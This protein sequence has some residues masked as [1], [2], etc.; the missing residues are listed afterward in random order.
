M[1][2]SSIDNEEPNISHEDMINSF[3]NF[4]WIKKRYKEFAGIKRNTKEIYYY[5]FRV[6]YELND[7]SPIIMFCKYI[8]EVTTFPAHNFEVKIVMDTKLKKTREVNCIRQFLMYTVDK[9]WTYFFVPYNLMPNNKITRVVSTSSFCQN[10][11]SSNTDSEVNDNRKKTPNLIINN[12]SNKKRKTPSL[13]VNNSDNDT[14]YKKRRNSLSNDENDYNSNNGTDCDSNYDT[15]MDN[16]GKKRANSLL[17]SN[18][19]NDYDSNNDI[20]KNNNG[21]KRTNSLDSFEF[22]TDELDNLIKFS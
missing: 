10:N 13:I 6:S 5:I 4:N 8:S 1:T 22:S 21:K 20:D 3:N 17:L 18:D 9:P 7:I 15:D 19:E 16:N 14:N 11:D 12:N 2:S